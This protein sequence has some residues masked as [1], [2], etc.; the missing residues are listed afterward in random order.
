MFCQKCG[1]QIADGQRF[2]PK[3]GNCVSSNPPTMGEGTTQTGGTPWSVPLMFV[4]CVLSLIP[5][6]GLIM[7]AC[8]HKNPAKKNQA[9]TLLWISAVAF[10]LSFLSSL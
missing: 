6:F 5:L 3:C 7:W 1:N 10:A 8:N 9:T 4:F 2:C